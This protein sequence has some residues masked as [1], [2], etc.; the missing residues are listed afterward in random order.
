MFTPPKSKSPWEAMT[1]GST[2]GWA[3]V[4]APG[5]ALGFVGPAA[6]V[7]AGAIP[8]IG[9]AISAGMGAAGT[10]GGEGSWLGDTGFQGTDEGWGNLLPTILG[11]AGGWGAGQVGSSLG[12]GLGNVMSG[13]GVTA[14]GNIVGGVSPGATPSALDLFTQGFTSTG[15]GTLL[16]GGAPGTPGVSGIPGAATTPGG[17]GGL[18]DLGKTLL[19]AGI[20]GL[21]QMATKSMQP[22]PPQ[23]G[24]T[25]SKWLTGDAVTKIGKLSGEWA[26]QKFLGETWTP[27]DETNSMI[28][29]LEKDI[30]KSYEESF[31]KR[32]DRMAAYDPNYRRSGAFIEDMRENAQQMNDEIAQVKAQ[33]MYAD[34]QKFSQR[35]YDYV[36]G[37]I[38]ADEGVKRELLEGYLS[39]VALKYGV[40]QEEIL[41]LR[42]IANEAG[43]NIALEGIRGLTAGWGGGV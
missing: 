19:G 9:P 35:Q 10:M 14:G 2:G 7:A 41:Q 20:T 28:D 17:V 22:E 12:A 37:N 36:M 23:I 24:E 25:V 11:G 33:T 34:K 16:G 3:N 21:G 6:T 8:G 5:E 18:G 4:F 30:T 29:V 31:A 1:R 13:P 26:E 15:A 39:D 43:M 42:Q 38:Q 40:A 32:S 27:S